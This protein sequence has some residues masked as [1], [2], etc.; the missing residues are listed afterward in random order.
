MAMRKKG[1]KKKGDHLR[2]LLTVAL[3][4]IVLGIVL[5]VLGRFGIVGYIVY[6][7]LDSS[8]NQ[9]VFFQPLAAGCGDGVVSGEQCDDGNTHDSDGCSSQCVIDKGWRCTGQPSSCSWMQPIGIP[10]PSFGIEETHWMYLD[11]T[12]RNSALTY[13]LGPNG[14]YTHYVDNSVGAGCTDTSNPYGTV[15]KPRCSVPS[16]TDVI[17]EGSVVE[18]HGG[19]YVYSRWIRWT[20]QGSATRPV[21]IRG[22][23]VTNRV[24][25]TL[26]GNQVRLEGS[27][28]ILENIEFTGGT[29]ALGLGGWGAATDHYSIRNNEIHT[30]TTG[31]GINAK[32]SDLIMYNN[33]IHDISRYNSAGTLIDAHGIVPGPFAQRVWIVDNHIHHNTGDSIQA[34]HL[35]FDPRPEFVYIGRNYLHDDRE[36]AVD[37]KLVR[38]AIVSQNVMHGYRATPT[39]NGD[40]IV[41]GSDRAPTRVWILFNEIYDSQNAIKNEESYGGVG[42]IGNKIH[43]I[44]GIALYLEK[45]ASDGVDFIGNTISGANTGI[46]WKYNYPMRIYNNVFEGI[47]GR[48]VDFAA[49]GSS[50]IGYNLFWKNG[51]AITNR[52]GTSYST[53][54]AFTASGK[55]PGCIEGDPLFVDK[56]NKDYH[57]RSGSPAIDSGFLETAYQTFFGLYGI[58]ISRDYDGNVRPAGAGWDMGAFEYGSS[59]APPPPLPPPPDITP[60]VISAVV[61]TN[62]LSDSATVSWTT[63]EVS[64]TQVEYGTTTSY[65]S[66][67][68]LNSLFVTSHSASIGGLQPNTLYHYRVRSRDRAGNL[69]VS[70]DFTFT[71]Q[72]QTPLPIPSSCIDGDSDGFDNCAPGTGGDDGKVIDCNDANPLEKPG[73]TW[74]KDSDNDGYSDGISVTQ[75]LRPSGYKTSGELS[76]ISG[77]CNDNNPNIKPGVSDSVCNGVDDNCDGRVDEGY[78]PSATTCGLGAC[79]GNTGQLT[80]SNGVLVNTCDPNAGAIPE[81]CSDNS[82]YDG[83]DNNCDGVVDLN[84][85]SYCDKDGDT[86]SSNLLCALIFY[87]QGDCNDDDASVHPGAGEVCNGIDDDCD[88]T[89]VDGSGESWYGSVTLCGVGACSASGA[90]LCQGGIR[91]DSC[92]PG[93]PS[94]EICGNG[95]DE[96]CSGSDNVCLQLPL[97]NVSDPKNRIYKNT[98]V[99]LRFKAVG[100]ANCWYVLNNVPVLSACVSDTYLPRMPAGSYTIVIVANNSL[101]EVSESRT[102]DV[103]YTRKLIIKYSSFEAQGTTTDLTNANDT[104][105]ENV[106]LTLN[107]PSIGTIEFLDSVN[108]SA[109]ADPVSNE[110]DIEAN[111]LVSYNRIEVKSDV[112]QGLKKKARLTFEGLS[113]ANPRILKDGSACAD[114]VIESYSGGTLVF[115]VGEFSVYSVQETSSGGGGDG[116]GGGSGGG[117]SGGGGSGGGTPIRGSSSNRTGALGVPGES[118]DRGEI[119]HRIDDVEEGTQEELQRGKVERFERTINLIAV[120]SSLI[121]IVVV[122]VTLLILRQ[123]RRL[124][125]EQSWLGNSP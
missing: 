17:P 110:T 71:T 84:C 83:V 47:T 73:Q 46:H 75:C 77:D 66:M 96:D 41:L 113:F 100:A 24:K 42:I 21:F 53:L 86:Y 85:G 35:C 3:V 2:L 34:C 39:S 99:P 52:W 63:N 69:A 123:R 61:S 93:T 29:T 107:A 95:V 76:G 25:Y 55:C 114:C 80:C 48:S 37:F 117:S 26:T 62:V 103:V 36:N 122:I 50:S 56:V 33:H 118:Q 68:P 6:S 10:K 59:G 27:Y 104:A 19:P 91:V 119:A 4:L 97:L 31:A 45:N 12:K 57:L 94:S 105:L 115:T 89:T 87:P 64:D 101:G 5:F 111:V 28:T 14:P 22:Y 65:G 20:T 108:L 70:T 40:A 51:N 60:P 88:A 106:S 109:D 116:G 49:P 15:S 23:D 13:T 125:E 67:T 90:S 81:S 82:G 9:Q 120:I 102:F 112:L 58:D 16:Y 72:A 38:D 32:G 78:V 98:R 7:R 92:V 18:I 1:D 30:I 43:D 79:V 74:Y 121:G 44:L 11:A 124:E 8:L 54:A